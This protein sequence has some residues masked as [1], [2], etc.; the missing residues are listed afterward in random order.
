MTPLFY[1]PSPASGLFFIYNESMKIRE[2]LISFLYAFI[3]LGLLALLVISCIRG[4]ALWIISCV[5]ILN[6]TWLIAG[7]LW[8][9]PAPITDE[10]GRTHLLTGQVLKK[11]RKNLLVWGLLCGA[12]WVGIILLLVTVPLSDETIQT[13]K[14]ISYCVPFVSLFIGLGFK[15]L[16]RK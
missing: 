12:L 9:R 15:Y 14:I 11:D 3:M 8:G 6:I 13:L 10:N 16:G 7:I 2:K 5:L 1:F 4:L